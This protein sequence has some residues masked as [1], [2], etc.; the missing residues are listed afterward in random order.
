MSCEV[1][2]EGPEMANMP[3]AVVSTAATVPLPRTR[4]VLLSRIILYSIQPTISCFVFLKSCPFICWQTISMLVCISFWRTVWNISVLPDSFYVSACTIVDYDTCP[5]YYGLVQ[6]CL[7]ESSHR[8]ILDSTNASM[9]MIQAFCPFQASRSLFLEP[10]NATHV[11]Y[12]WS[13]L[14]ISGN[15]NYYYLFTHKM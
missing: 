3:A 1:G 7:Y 14:E 4:F 13:T 5:S 10:P 11:I 12:H 2:V 9:L 8:I 15:R 6:S